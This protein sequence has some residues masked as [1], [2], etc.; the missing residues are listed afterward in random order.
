MPTPIAVVVGIIENTTGHVLI[1]ERPAGKSWASYW[2]FPG[3]KVEAGESHEDALIR[4]FH[5]ELGINL[6]GET[7]T[8]FYHG[9]RDGEVI[10]D[11]YR[12]QATQVLYPKSMEGQL[13][14]WVP[15]SDLTQ[16][17]FPE[18]NTIVLQKLQHA[19]K[20]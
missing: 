9:Q 1:A 16:Y 3:G 14:R 5:E 7:F 11:F 17:R 10:L 18:P 19:H 12:C 20:T 2:E 6:S 8:H 13:W 4:E 15:I